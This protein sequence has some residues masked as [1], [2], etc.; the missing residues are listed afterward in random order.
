MAIILYTTWGFRSI[1]FCRTFK[2][3]T[4]VQSSCHHISFLLATVSSIKH[5]LMH[6]YYAQEDKK[7][8]SRHMAYIPHNETTLTI[9]CDK[10]RKKSTILNEKKQYALTYAFHLK[11]SSDWERMRR[12][13]FNLK[14]LYYFERRCT[15]QCDHLKQYISWVKPK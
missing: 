6:V 10:R 1:R 12:L 8:T 15:V 4:N 11:H 2:K 13:H 7:K 14:R 9:S 3:H 5:K